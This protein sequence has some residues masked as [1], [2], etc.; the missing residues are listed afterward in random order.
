MCLF[1]FHYIYCIPYSHFSWRVHAFKRFFSQCWLAL[2]R[3]KAVNS[4]CLSDLVNI[5]M[6]ACHF[7]SDLLH[8]ITTP[9]PSVECVVFFSELPVIYLTWRLVKTDHYRIKHFISI[10]NM[11]V[12]DLLQ[13]Y[14]C[15]MMLLSVWNQHFI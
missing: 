1:A 9:T 14:R 10:I 4:S 2:F 15:V 11:S 7:R 5:G 3:L 12:N 13:N 8:T 6:G